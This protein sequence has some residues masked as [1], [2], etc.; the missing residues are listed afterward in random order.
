MLRSIR[1]KLALTILVAVA[2]AGLVG[3]VVSG[4]RTANRQF[5]S[6]SQQLEG[7]A[8]TLA[9]AAAPAQARKDYRAVQN[10]L[11]AIGRI[12]RVRYAEVR[13]KA[14][15][16]VAAFGNGV[17][18]VRNAE[19]VAR[20]ER[21]GLLELLTLKTY[22]IEAPIIR[23][24]ENVGSLYMI[25]DVSELGGILYDNLIDALAWGVL[26]ALLGVFI[27]RPLEKSVSAPLIA[28]SRAMQGVCARH[29]YSARVERT[30][31]DETGRLVD[32]F[33]EMLDQIQSRDSALARHR[34]TLEA[35]VELRTSELR[36]ATLEAQ[37]A[38]S[39]KS[40]FLATMSHEIRTPM[41][42]ML[43]MAELLNASGLPPKLQRYSDV[44]VTSGKSLL[45]IINDILDFS[46][47]EAGK[48]ELEA[49]PVEPRKLVDD[50]VSL[51]AERATSSD[52]DIAA[53][54]DPTVP[55]TIAADP[56]RLMQVLSNLVSNALKFTEDGGISIRVVSAQDR[57]RFEIVDTGI[58][59]PEDK[60]Q[61]VF[62]AFS[63]ADQSTTRKFGGTGIG[64][65]ICQR[66]ATAMEGAIEVSSVEGEGS[67]FA[68]VAPFEV[69][70]AEDTTDDTT[71]EVA[72][73]PATKTTNVLDLDVPPGPTRTALV[74]YAAAYEVA[75]AIAGASEDHSQPA[76]DAVR[77]SF[78]PK[79]KLYCLSHFAQDNPKAAG[80]NGP[81][82]QLSWPISTGDA[83]RLMAALQ[84]GD[85]GD[86]KKP[87]EADRDTAPKLRQ[88]PGVHVLAADDSAINREVLTETLRRL[89]V[90][91]TCVEDGAEA[92]SEIQNNSYDLV[93]MDGS[94]PVLD[95]F[96]ATRRIR[97]WE[98][99][100]GRQPTP[101]VALTAHVV[102]AQAER[103]RDAGMEDC[104]TKP[105]NL[106]TIE[107]CLAKWLP[108]HA[109]EPKT[110]GD[111]EAEREPQDAPNAPPADVPEV[112]A[113]PP[114][115]T[116]SDTM[117]SGKDRWSSEP[118]L[119]P[120]VLDEI[121]AMQ[122][123]A[124]DALVDRIV[125]LYKSHAP[126]ALSEIRSV[127]ESDD[128]LEVARAVHALKS[129]SRNIGAVRVSEI[130]EDLETAA[131]DGVH[132]KGADK[133]SDLATAL[134]ATIAS[135]SDDQSC[136]RPAAAV[137]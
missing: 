71:S 28:L 121:R 82:T 106:A 56:V 26:A 38:N 36:T 103:W 31:N 10:T 101:V 125:G 90:E 91:I 119:D 54:V 98:S 120:T 55:K 47:I 92:V 115:S 17:I 57:L 72:E 116:A 97:A 112:Y 37:Q 128:Q 88:F 58:G 39:A 25:A 22:P 108:D 89:S 74:D 110:S 19:T 126:E 8:A 42:G 3:A 127:W 122:P 105:F 30:T 102:G 23:G 68:L 11:A 9:I 27:A 33:N 107:A 87:Q 69:L 2:V 77:L 32:A 63:Q 5:D 1:T 18:L 81:I 12:K 45:S 61:A 135:F 104:V 100:E 83:G 50:V 52:L 75:I 6:I 118:L 16:R 7:V 48:M 4:F 94:M 124:G 78:D 21:P 130:C 85:F 93:F 99:E 86:L 131:R 20:G 111:D 76:L 13:N 24:G 117:L 46:K 66:L 14:G 129:L 113:E 59:I 134:D 73:Q 84:S 51:F 79:A 114:P 40:E 60:L 35:T 53:Y 65:A 133:L 34:D 29:D 49:I 62:E 132:E 41:N 123:D 96:E 109:V 137:G 44:I 80:S 43:V 15:I 136:A 67:T 95:G 64:L 70:T